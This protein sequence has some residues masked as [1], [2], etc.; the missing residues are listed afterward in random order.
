MSVLDGATGKVVD[1]LK[2]ADNALEIIHREGV[3]YI[4]CGDLDIAK[5]RK[6]RSASPPP[7][8]KRLVAIKADTGE[9]L[10]EKDGKY[11][12]EL[13][14]LTLASSEGRI[15]F[16]NANEIVCL[17]ASD[18]TEEWRAVRPIQKAR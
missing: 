7:T 4:V 12:R 5:V 11:T 1:V 8:N 14:P 18:G 9:V 13:M 16:Q 3:L 17:K 6:L 15:F 2:E 10:W